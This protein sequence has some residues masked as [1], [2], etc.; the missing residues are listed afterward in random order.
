M[1]HALLS[2]STLSRSLAAALLLC[3]YVSVVLLAFTHSKNPPLTSA[4]A[5]ALALAGKS[6]AGG[7]AGD[8]TFVTAIWDEAQVPALISLAHSLM[9]ARSEFGLL[10]LLPTGAG[11]EPGGAHAGSR[12]RRAPV[13][14]ATKITTTPA[15]R[16]KRKSG[17]NAGGIGGAGGDA[18]SFPIDDDAAS[19]PAGSSSNGDVVHAWSED[20]LAV[21]RAIPNLTLQLLP[22]VRFP[23]KQS[24]SSATDARVLASEGSFSTTQAAQADVSFTSAV[25]TLLLFEI[26]RLTEFQQVLY[27]DVNSIVQRNIDHLLRAETIE[28]VPLGAALAK[29]RG[30]SGGSGKRRKLPKATTTLATTK[31]AAASDSA[32]ATAAGVTTLS[33]GSARLSAAGA[34]TNSESDSPEF[35]DRHRRAEVV[36][37]GLERWLHAHS[38]HEAHL[39]TPAPDVGSTSPNLAASPGASHS[40]HAHLSSIDWS[41]AVAHSTP[42]YLQVAAPMQL[43]SEDCERF[44]AVAKQCGRDFDGEVATHD[45]SPAAAAAASAASSS[46]SGA[47]ASNSKSKPPSLEAFSISGHTSLLSPSLSWSLFNSNLLLLTPN[48]YT[49][50]L[51]LQSY[52]HT[53][54]ER[55]DRFDPRHFEHRLDR[56]KYGNYPGKILNHFFAR[57]CA[58]SASGTGHAATA[59]EASAAAASP[60][61]APTSGCWHPLRL[62]L[63]L[64]SHT[65][66][67]LGPPELHSAATQPVMRY[68]ACATPGRLNPWV[69]LPSSTATTLRECDQLTI[70]SSGAAA[71]AGGGVEGE[72][73]SVGEDRASFATESVADPS[74]LSFPPGFSPASSASSTSAP[75]SSASYYSALLSSLSWLWG[76]SAE[77][78]SHRFAELYLI[79]QE[80]KSREALDEAAGMGI[81]VGGNRTTSASAS[82]AQSTV[83]EEDILSPCCHAQYGRVLDT[84]YKAL[85]FI[86]PSFDD[87]TQQANR[88]T[89]KK[90]AGLNRRRGGG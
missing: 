58:A 9:Q 23:P 31:E 67:C 69:L 89:R 65:C 7:G 78:A 85:R 81:G 28:A 3:I 35:D 27:I 22:H 47:G 50:H 53:H 73:T 77:R 4:Q 55:R 87:P 13:R 80:S 14:R 33:S 24:L 52:T 38:M 51:L 30:G 74:T 5:E 6:S 60:L 82:E 62:N 57:P 66:G 20:T 83:A 26:W 59:G 8:R 64:T 39:P 2:S 72:T 12:S 75:A 56:I 49:Y 43:A 42:A 46:S 40:F 32:A 16:R 48:A 36:D 19:S 29:Q 10:L 17:K 84:Y 21:L 25:R 34:S 88:D 76:S 54:V 1:C 86:R 61:S 18:D 11:A 41:D 37:A 70:Q 68:T 63:S 45:H 90:G 15:S 79:E 71:G 44:E